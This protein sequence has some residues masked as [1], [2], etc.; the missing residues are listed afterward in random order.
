MEFINKMKFEAGS[1]LLN[2]SD[3]AEFF[4]RTG[5]DSVLED[6]G[7]EQTNPFEDLNVIEFNCGEKAY[8]YSGN[9]LKSVKLHEESG[10]LNDELAA[11]AVTAEVIEKEAS[12]VAFDTPI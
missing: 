12:H 11:N 6:Y 9:Q 1:S 7:E 2:G 10:L 5:S 4:V 3:Q 8:R